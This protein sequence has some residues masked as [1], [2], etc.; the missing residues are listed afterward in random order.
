M[1]EVDG[2]GPMVSVSNLWGRHPVVALLMLLFM[3]PSAMAQVSL[4]PGYLDHFDA[5]KRKVVLRNGLSLAYLDLG[6]RDARPVIL[7]HGYTDSARDW[8]PIA[9]LLTP[10][11]RLVIV[12]LRGH[13]LSAKPDC[14]YTR[15]D[16]AED[17]KLLMDSLHIASAD[18]VGHSLGSI[19]AQ[20]FAELWP[21]A[22]RRLVLIS[23]TGTS[24][25][26]TESPAACTSNRPTV[27]AWLASVD[28]LNDPIDPESPFM[29]GWW[30]E[31]M[32]LNPPYFSR[33]QRR[34]AAA[35]PARIW[36]AIADQT[37]IGV[38]LRYML[39]RIRASTLLIWGE[40]DALADDAGREALRGGIAHAE[41]RTFAAVGHDLF[42]E[43]PW[44]V[45]AT[46]IDFLAAG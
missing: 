23:S 22:I 38:D 30:A 19:V 14:C 1:V 6:A 44:A 26:A 39:P 8:A 17:V 13:G 20:T 41:V 33:R 29:R 34:D 35:I 12:D 16:F 18:V 11:L 21:D 10:H 46:L 40:L 3:L 42:W 36:R 9:R 27:A 7:I 45:A 43:D 28:Q 15:F 37:L 32:R 2:D 31:S 25:G 5:Q 4:S 24:F